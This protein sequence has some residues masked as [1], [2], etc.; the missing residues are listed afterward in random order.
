MNPFD[1]NYKS[2]IDLTEQDRDA[3]R[4]KTLTKH[5]EK[6]RKK[7]PAFG[8]LYGIGE[9]VVEPLLQHTKEKNT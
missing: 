2:G 5:V 9:L 7:N 4:A 6:Q 8:T 3:R 1:K